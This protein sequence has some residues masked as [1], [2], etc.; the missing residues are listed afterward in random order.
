MFLI[1][2]LAMNHAYYIF[3]DINN[4]DV[5]KAF[6]I[7]DWLVAFLIVLDSPKEIFGGFIWGLVQ[8]IWIAEFRELNIFLDYAFVITDR[9]HPHDLHS[10]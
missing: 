5:G 1:T 2:I 4:F 6:F 8:I 9:F 7:F 10:G 3:A